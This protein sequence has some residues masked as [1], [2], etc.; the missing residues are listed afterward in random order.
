MLKLSRAQDLRF[1]HQYT[2]SLPGDTSRNPKRRQVRSLTTLKSKATSSWQ[3]SCIHVQVLGSLYSLVNPTPTLSKP[4]LVAWS[5]DMAATLGI[6]AE[7]VERQ[8]FSEVFSGNGAVPAIDGCVLGDLHAHLCC[9]RHAH[10]CAWVQ[11]VLRTLLRRP[12][13]WLCERPSVVLS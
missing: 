13:V 6:S 8:E 9:S 2:Q 1:E 5:E 10:W 4:Q 3:C 11:E 12:S 7:Q